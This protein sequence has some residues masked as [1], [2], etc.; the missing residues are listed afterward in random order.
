MNGQT[1]ERFVN[2]NEGECIASQ[3][4]SILWIGTKVGLVKRNLKDNSIEIFDYK[5]G[6]SSSTVNDLVFDSYKN[7]WMATDNGIVKYDG[8]DFELFNYKNNPSLPNAAFNK[9]EIDTNDNIYAS[10]KSYKRGNYYNYSS[11]VCCYEGVWKIFHGDDYNFSWHASDITYYNNRII[12]LLPFQIDIWTTKLFT[13]DNGELSQLGDFEINQYGHNLTIDYQDSLWLSCSRYLYKYRNNNWIEIINGED[14]GIGSLWIYAWSDKEKGLWLSG[15]HRSSLYHLNIE[16]NRNGIQNNSYLPA[17]MKR[18]NNIEITINGYLN[19]AGKHYFI[20]TES[21]V[22]LTNSQFTYY[23]IPKTTEQNEIFGLG[24]SP[25]N[26][27]LVSGPVATQKFDGINWIVIGNRSSGYQTYNDD[28]RFSLSGQLYTNN[29]DLFP[30]YTSGLD[31]DGQSNLWTTYPITKYKW[32]SLS[33]TQIS[34]EELGVDVPEKGRAP[35]FMDVIVDK[36]N[37]VWFVGWYGYIAMYDG[38]R[39]HSYD[40]DD[41]GIYYSLNLDY[42]FADSK[43]RKW[44]ADNQTSPNSGL[45]MYDDVNWNVINFPELNRGQYIYQAVED[46]L[47]NIW[48][49]SAAGLLKYNNKNWYIYNKDYSEVDFTSTK[50]VTVDERGNIWVGTDKGLYV[51][52]EMGVDLTSGL[53][54]S[55][56]DSFDVFYEEKKVVAKVSMNRVLL[57]LKNIELQKGLNPHKFW[58]VSK[59]EFSNNWLFEIVDTSLI[60]GHNFYRIKVVDYSGKAYFSNYQEIIGD[61]VGVEISKFY[62]EKRGNQLLFHWTSTNEQYVAYYELHSMDVSIPSQTLLSKVM[63]NTGT[64]VNNYTVVGENLVYGSVEKK[65]ILYTI[66]SDSTRTENQVLFETPSLPETFSVSKNFPNPFNSITKF[67]VSLPQYARVKIEIFNILGELVNL[68]SDREY[69]AGVYTIPIEFNEYSS[70]IYLYKV[71]ANKKYITGK[72]IFLK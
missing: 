41:V 37:H 60:L 40:S 5:N 62:A 50:A 9:I 63:V 53:E 43:G 52:N 12:I 10:T 16:D 21:L 54:I 29:S 13:F 70:G 25:K 6:L 47:G 32:P 68:V 26:E 65:Y 45:I 1:W 11:I 15:N 28:F 71:S 67:E 7:I 39:W 44:F 59:K 14:E 35:Q 55:P 31:F 4:D 64:S 38:S 20:S 51:Y 19:H 57:N 42:A 58:T 49:A 27:L 18:I 69:E 8:Q 23:Y 61:S 24:I 56:V 46:H 48:F 30:N 22:K 33:P 2:W 34:I 66:F 3:N 17:G 36:F 72:M